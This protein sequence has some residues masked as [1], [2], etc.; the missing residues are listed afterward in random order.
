MN[1][2]KENPLRKPG[3]L[4]VLIL[5]ALM[6]VSCGG[7]DPA[8]PEN[9]DPPANRAPGVPTIDTAAGTPADGAVDVPTSVTLNWKCTDPDNDVLSYTVH[10]GPTDTPEVVSTDQAGTSYGPIAMVNENT[11]HWK[12]VAKDPDGE[13]T[14]SPVWSFATVAEGVEV[15]SVPGTP[16]G[17]ATGETGESLLFSATGSVS[18]EGHAVE[19]QFSW[20]DGGDNSD[21]MNGTDA[22]HS[23]AAAG[24]YDVTA[25]ARCV[26][27]PEILSAWSAAFTVTVTDPAVET[28]GTPDTPSGPAT[29][30]TTATLAYTTSVVTSSLGHPVAYTFD[31]GDG[32][33]TTMGINQANHNWLAAGTYDIK[34]MAYCAQH[35]EIVSAWSPTTQVTITVP[36]ETI[37]PPQIPSNIADVTGVGEEEWVTCYATSSNLGHDLEYRFDLENDGTF[38][39]WSTNRTLF[40]TWLT[41]GTY[42][43]RAQARCIEHPGVVSD[44]TTDGYDHEITVSEG[45]ET[46]TT[47]TFLPEGEI[48]YKVDEGRGYVA[49]GA[50][51]S[52]G[53]ALQYEFDWGN[54]EF[55]TWGGST[56]SYAY[57]AMGIFEARVRARC[58]EHPDIVSEW[59]AITIVN[60]VESITRPTLSGPSVGIVGN[61][62]TFTTSG[63]TSSEG[64]D[65]EYR[66][67]ASTS[68]GSPGD[69]LPWTTIDNLIHTFPYART[70]YVWVQ[71]RCIEDLTEGPASTPHYISISAK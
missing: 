20:G 56:G 37:Q 11:F 28:V 7:D 38:T 63:S 48:T 8:A 64:H 44:W 32:T 14:S 16:T 49:S 39:A 43:I 25:R 45:I 6:V 23:W 58:I 1:F 17:S 68:Q 15:V 65:L 24:T 69:P 40:Y 52:L 34:V 19:Y 51:S 36:G 50:A 66:L 13:T 47:P 29:G 22:A 46:I 9:D 4:V 67:Y 12:I 70:W 61:P 3:I 42:T 60:I 53:H 54:G 10:F 5:M 55:S 18:S 2:S 27:H 35:P 26:T 30:E 62:I 33:D 59:S 57:P 31:W 21:F 41:A 71:A